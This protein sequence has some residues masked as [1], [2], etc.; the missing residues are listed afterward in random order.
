[1]RH[2]MQHQ[3]LSIVRSLM[4]SLK[5]SAEDAMRRMG[6]SDSDQD[7]YLKLLKQSS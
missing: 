1:M 7:L 6:L 5:I 2:E 4:N 3:M